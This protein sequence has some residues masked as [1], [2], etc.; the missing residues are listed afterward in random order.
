MI[1]LKMAKEKA[2]KITCK[3]IPSLSALRNWA[4]LGCIEKPSDYYEKG[5]GGRIGKYSDSLP[6]QIAITAEMKKENYTLNHF[7]F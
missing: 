2:Q 6:I 7:V 5:R 1:T 4:S 3:S